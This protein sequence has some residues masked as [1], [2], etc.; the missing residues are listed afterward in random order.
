MQRF[1]LISLMAGA[2]AE[3]NTNGDGESLFHTMHGRSLQDIY[4][5]QSS[6]V[7]KIPVKLWDKLRH[8]AL[9]PVISCKLSGVQS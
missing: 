4:L 8:M 9:S 7:K 2:A 5:C 3:R 1:Y 6:C